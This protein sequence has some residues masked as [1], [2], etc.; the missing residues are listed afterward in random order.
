M[1]LLEFRGRVHPL[2]YPADVVHLEPGEV[3]ML[4][5]LVRIRLDSLA[6]IVAYCRKMSAAV[7]PEVL[8]DSGRL[9]E[10]ERKLIRL[11]FG[12]ES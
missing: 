2:D 6:D 5:S 9:Q 8:D 3:S 11:E 7:P 10:L 1:K 4:R 12:R